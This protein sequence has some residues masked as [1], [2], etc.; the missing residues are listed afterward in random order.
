MRAFASTDAFGRDD[1]KVGVFSA[2]D[3][4]S[5]GEGEGECAFGA[6]FK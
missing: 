2:L 1:G 4:R 5:A 3:G 6:V